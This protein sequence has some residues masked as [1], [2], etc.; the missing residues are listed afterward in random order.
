MKK[1]NQMIGLLSMIGA[2]SLV[3]G[4][5]GGGGSKAGAK[6][7]EDGKTIIKVVR[8]TQNMASADSKQVKAVQDAINDYIK[9]KIDV[10]LDY[11]EMPAG[12]YSNKVNL[13]L[14]NGEID[15]FWTANWMGAIST[16]DLVQNNG[17]YDITEIL[18]GSQLEE[19]LPADVWD[20]SSYNGKNY[21]VP[22]YKEIAEGYSLMFRKELVDQFGWD[23]ST[24][25]ELKDIEPMLA[26]SKAA[27]IK[28][29][30]LTQATPFAYK[31]FLDDYAWITGNDYIGVDRE[32]NEVVEVIKT[33]EYVEYIKMMSDWGEKGYIQ[34]GDITNTN[35]TD[36]LNTDFWG[37]SWW[38]DVPNN[39]SASSRYQQEVEMVHMTQNYVDSNTTLGST[40]AIA[41]NTTEEAAKASVDFLGLLYSDETLANL[42]TYGIEGE[43]YDM[44]DGF[45]VKKGEKYDHSAWES[46]NVEFVALEEGEPANKVE[47]YQEFNKNAEK[48]ITAGFRFDASNSSAVIS[49]VNNVVAKYG[50]VL[51]SGGYPQADV[52]KVLE[53]YYSALDE[54]GYQELVKDV[55]DQYNAWKTK[56]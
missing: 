45:I 30:L 13:S 31:F 54:A 56:Q 46:T 2:L 55:T 7:T 19:R 40:Y 1:N 8:P 5:C 32:K 39:A 35:P 6:T 4:A 53:E 21:F 14:A 38:T 48:S 24:V 27:G 43:D 41:S 51:Q 36:S 22:V 3:L 23:L 44:V 9:D 42:F 10:Q 47:L 26:D 16:D 50:F 37:I 49:A 15:L 20:A 17:A 34:E 11:E 29:P 25:K 18:K 28:A 12:E 52:D 33:D